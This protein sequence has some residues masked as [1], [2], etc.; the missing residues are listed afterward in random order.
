MRVRRVSTAQPYD[1]RRRSIPLELENKIAVLRQDDGLCSTGSVKDFSI[2]RAQKPE[3][4][5]RGGC[6]TKFLFD[7]ICDRGGDLRINPDNHA[8]K[9]G[10]SRDRAAKRRQACK[11]P[12]SRSGISSRISCEERPAAKR[13][14]T[15]VTRMRIKSARSGILVQRL[16]SR[17]IQPLSTP[18]AVRRARNCR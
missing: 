9:T 5:S 8:T 12:G 1:L 7:E 4:A 13:S 14:R 16:V 11:S 18:R 2:V 17:A 10:W 6:H 3:T 15:S